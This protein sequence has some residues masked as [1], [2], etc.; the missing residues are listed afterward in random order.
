MKY[1]CRLVAVSVSV[2]GFGLLLAGC[3]ESSSG[4]DSAVGGG[5]VTAM[6]GGAGMG[7]ATDT[8]GVTGVGGGTTA[9]PSC[10]SLTPPCGGDAVGTWSVTASCVTISGALDVSKTG[11]GCGS[12]PLVVGT[13]EVSG[14]WT[15]NA[16]GTYVDNTTTSG[17]AKFEL[18]SGCLSV[19]S[20]TVTC[21]KL[22]RALPV[23]GFTSGTCVANAATGGCSCDA[24][25]QQSGGLGVV[26]SS[27]A[28]SGT[29]TAAGTV[30]TATAGGFNEQYGYCVAGSALTVTVPAGK[31]GTVAGGVILQKQ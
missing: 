25:I 19:S 20:T 31:G 6:G 17:T 21:P 4:N 27:A 11:M 7:G 10:D 2:L 1:R 30:L 9:A 26:S 13:M 28:A 5:G 15:L 8:G 24:V 18:D 22:G 16:D 29:Y 14:T 12:A 3:G 23:A